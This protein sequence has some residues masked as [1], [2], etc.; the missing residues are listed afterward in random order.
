[1]SAQADSKAVVH[2]EALA[3][4]A[5][6]QKLSRTGSFDWNVLTGEITW[7]DET[8]RIFEYPSTQTPTMELVMA[9]IHPADRALVQQTIDRASTER[10]HL[11]SNIAC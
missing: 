2:H 6:A 10:P 8:F 3:N 11:M 7:S 5:E 9:R 4:L 1:M